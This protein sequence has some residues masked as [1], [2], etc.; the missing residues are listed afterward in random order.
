MPGIKTRFLG[1]TNYRGSR[2]VAESLDNRPSTGKPD[3]LIL[4]WDR[5][6]G[7][8][9]NHKRAALALAT[10]HGWS[11]TYTY[12]DARDGYVFAPFGGGREVLEVA[13]A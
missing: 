5:R 1:P 6:L 3:R 11:G 4:G 8:L 12:V 13:R 9:E 2:V 10:R 7:I